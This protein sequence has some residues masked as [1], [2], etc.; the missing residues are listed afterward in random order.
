[1]FGVK[2]CLACFALHVIFIAGVSSCIAQDPGGAVS[3]EISWCYVDQQS[4]CA[5]AVV[6]LYQEGQLPPSAVLGCGGCEPSHSG[7]R[8]CINNG[9]FVPLPNI[10][11]TLAFASSGPFN[12]SGKDSVTEGATV[13][14]GSLKQCQPGCYTVTIVNPGTG[15]TQTVERCHMSDINNTMPIKSRVAAGGPCDPTAL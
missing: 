15:L 7:G 2:S 4:S 6:Y 12:A 14:C 8:I 10:N 3:A 9:S 1:M 13:E 5:D 11:Q